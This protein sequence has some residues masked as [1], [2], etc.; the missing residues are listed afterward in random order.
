MRNSQKN[1]CNLYPLN[2]KP[3]TTLFESC[4][5]YFFRFIIIINISVGTPNTHTIILGIATKTEYHVYS[6]FQHSIVI[7]ADK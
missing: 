1:L 4:C 5:K 2:K 6:V 7:F 3:N